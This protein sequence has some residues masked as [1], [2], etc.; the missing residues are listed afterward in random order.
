[1]ASFHHDSVVVIGD[2]AHAT[3]PQLG[4]GT[5]LALVDAVTLARCVREE[6]MVHAA[7]ARYTQQRIAHTRYYSQASRLLTPLFQSDQKVLPWL[8]DQLMARTSA[9]PIL[10]EANLQTLVGTRG[11]WL[12][13]EMTSLV[14]PNQLTHALR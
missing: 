14:E 6:N 2:A 8:R 1:M 11:G 9:W 4:Q 3:S 10:R 12:R 7:L 13:G 5:N